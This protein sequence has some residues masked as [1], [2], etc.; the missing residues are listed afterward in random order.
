MFTCCLCF[1]KRNKKY[2]ESNISRKVAKKRKTRE[3]NNE[4]LHAVREKEDKIVSKVDLLH[5]INTL[6]FL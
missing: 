5:H 4:K 6:N 2:S 1:G 3:L